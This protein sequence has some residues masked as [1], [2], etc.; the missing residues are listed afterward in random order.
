M[1]RRQFLTTTG[2]AVGTAAFPGLAAGES[3]DAEPPD[4]NAYLTNEQ[5]TARLRRLNAESDLISLRRIGRS[6]G[7]RAPIWE[8]GVGRGGTNVHLITQIHGDEPAGTDA[9]LHVFEQMIAEPDR[10]EAVLDALTI[11]V[12]PQVNPD[13]AMFGWDTDGDGDEERITRRQNTQPWNADR[14]RHEPYYHYETGD[15]HPFTAP[16]PPPGYDMNRDFN[17]RADPGT[18]K[19]KLGG[20]TPGAGRECLPSDWWSDGDAGWQLD[21]PYEGYML[22]RSGLQLAPEVRAV[23]R[24]FLE[25]DPDYAI[26]HHHQGLATV[27]D[28]EP[29]QPSVMSVMAAFG[30]AYLDEAP[31][32]EGDGPI[33]DAVNP[34]IDR[35]TS[36]RSLRLNRLVTD[37]LGEATG[38]WDD[39]ESVTRYGYTTLW[40]SYLDTLCPRT[41][42]AGMLYEI[43]G[44]SDSVGSR[45]YGQKLEASRVG[46]LET[47]RALADDPHLSS[48]D[49]SGYFDIPLAGDEYSEVTDGSEDP[50]RTTPR[51]ANGTPTI[52]PDTPLP[53]DPLI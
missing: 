37:R 31:F 21:M 26:T 1:N 29:P 22:K 17:I 19:L 24:S 12:V 25:A 5:L 20:G 18:P 9:I 44:Q 50:G 53:R 40:G 6:A 30:E 46:F 51:G 7:R 42:A 49:A 15:D 43:S 45:A 48:V 32:Y 33:E 8:V 14:S 35:E 38:P 3:D 47:F 28:T 10:F 13:G 16:D 27:P 34:F 2:L 23:T 52:T 4:P 11:T 41:G 39:F 36:E